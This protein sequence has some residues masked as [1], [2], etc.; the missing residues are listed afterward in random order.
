MKKNQYKA[1]DV[2]N[3]GKDAHDLQITGKVLKVYVNFEQSGETAY[4]VEIK[5]HEQ[6]QLDPVEI[7]GHSLV[8]G[9]CDHE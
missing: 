2:V 5:Q 1:G 4:A 8:E 6:H 3:L 9:L 7:M